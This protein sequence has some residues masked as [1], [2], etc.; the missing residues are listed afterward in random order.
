MARMNLYGNGLVSSGGETLLYDGLRAVRQTT[1]SGPAVQWSGSYQAFG[2]PSSS[3]GSTGNHY[4][5][6]RGAATARTGSG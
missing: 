5:W 6:G 4:Q 1:G 2:Q 3:S